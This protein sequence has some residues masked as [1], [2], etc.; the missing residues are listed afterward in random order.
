MERGCAVNTNQI[1]T[2]ST[3]EEQNDATDA[4]A[5][6]TLPRDGYEKRADPDKLPSVR[7][8]HRNRD[9]WI[10]ATPGMAAKAKQAWIKRT[11]VSWHDGA[12]VPNGWTWALSLYFAP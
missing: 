1:V 12:P 8:L 4:S 5:S 7:L 9:Q 6:E 2:G 3:P 10:D 11:V